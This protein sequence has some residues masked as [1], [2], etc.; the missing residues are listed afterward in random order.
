MKKT[1][2]QSI[3]EI[4]SKLTE[5]EKKELYHKC[6]SII[7]LHESMKGAYFYNSPIHAYSRRRYEDNN[8]QN[9]TIVLDGITYI[10]EQKTNCSAKN[11]YYTLYISANKQSEFRLNISFIK[12]I[13]NALGI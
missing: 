7:S 2:K 12:N 4:C 10:V 8:S 9:T 6:K 5:E 13:L 3:A 1:Q 11:V